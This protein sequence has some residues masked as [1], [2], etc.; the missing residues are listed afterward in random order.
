MPL[1]SV[2]PATGALLSEYPELTPAEIEEK[3]ARAQA[4]F[5]SWKG[6]T[7]VERAVYLQKMAS[8]LRTEKTTMAR[9]AALEMGKTIKAAEAELEKCAVTCEYYATNAERFLSHEALTLPVK[10]SYVTFEPLGIVLAV[11]PWNFPYWQVYRFLAP[12]LMAGNVGLLKHASNVP[13]CAE[14]IEAA[15][16][17]CGFPE[18]VFQNMLVTSPQVEAIIRDPRVMAVTLTGSEHAGS[19]VAK[20][21]G[22]EL[23][24]TVLE[25]GGSDPFLVLADADVELAAKTAATVRMQLNAG[26]SCI[27]AKRFIVHQ[28]IAESFTA[29]L[30]AHLAALNVG[31]PT[32]PGTDVGPLAN[33]RG[34]ADLEQQVNRSVALGAKIVTGGTRVGDQGS[35]YAPT[36][37][38]DVKKGMPVYDEETFGPVAAVITVASE[39]EAIQVANDTIY[40]LAATIFSANIERA[41]ELA[42]HLEAGA[43]FINCPV[44]SDPAAPFGGIKKSG[45]GRELSHYGLKEF[46]NIKTMVIG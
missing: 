8:Y 7:F 14:A 35:F 44:K 1:R 27:A 30:A 21:A 32:D 6:K 28:E 15:V 16:R 38:T 9:L 5:P 23:K 37:L 42:T 18:G 43:V 46:V 11:M 34:L 22:E 33:A 31:D 45:Y 25:L 41:K 20:V 26:Q 29:K 39:E 24:K 19:M 12:A 2:N 13:Q 4:V 40:G 3:I 17:A 10:E 36:V